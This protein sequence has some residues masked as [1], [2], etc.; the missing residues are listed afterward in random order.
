MTN[1]YCAPTA[2]ATR[3]TLS[4]QAKDRIEAV[5]AAVGIILL[6]PGACLVMSILG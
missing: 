1:A 6:L 3:A 2:A 5:V 4:T